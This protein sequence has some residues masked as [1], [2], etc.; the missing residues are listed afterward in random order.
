MYSNVPTNELIKIIALMCD[1]HDIQE[2]M[3]QEIMKISQILIKQNHFQFQDKLCIQEEGL[4]MDETTSSA[5]AEMYLQYIENTKIFDILLTHHI[6]GYFLYIDILIVHNRGKTNRYGFLNIFNNIKPTMKFTMEEEKENNTNFLD[7]T[8]S[9][10]ENNISFDIYRKPA[11]TDNINP[12]D[13]S[14]PPRT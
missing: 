2:D 3:K 11:T 5:C 14:H 10:E 13:S 1:Q 9:K 8:I 12:S 4:A 7:I 6:T